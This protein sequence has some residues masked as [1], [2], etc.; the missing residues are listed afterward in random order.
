MAAGYVG[1]GRGGPLEEV[2]VPW[3]RLQH[4][5]TTPPA[6]PGT[7]AG[8]GLGLGTRPCQAEGAGPGHTEASVTS[9]QRQACMLRPG[10]VDP[11][12]SL[13]LEARPSPALS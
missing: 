6:R 4:T 2:S 5:I 3:P 9:L 13:S 1:L 7:W 12:L 8:G 10:A 11:V